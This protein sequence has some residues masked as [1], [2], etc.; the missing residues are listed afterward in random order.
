M[1]KSYLLVISHTHW[2]W[3]S[4]KCLRFPINS[5]VILQSYVNVDQRVNI[6]SPCCFN[7]IFR[8]SRFC[9]SGDGLSDTTHTLYLEVEAIISQ[10]NPTSSNMARSTIDGSFHGKNHGKKSM[11]TS[12]INGLLFANIQFADSPSHVW[13]QCFVPIYWSWR[14]SYFAYRPMGVTGGTRREARF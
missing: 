5:M 9:L 8:L 1:Q 13:R 7:Q 11:E 14:F 12:A 4:R 3:P 2:K 6:P 10:R